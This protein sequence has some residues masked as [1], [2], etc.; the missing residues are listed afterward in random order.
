PAGIGAARGRGG[1][2]ARRPP[3]LPRGLADWPGPAVPH[4]RRPGPRRVAVSCVPACVTIIVVSLCIGG[5]AVSLSIPFIVIFSA[6]GILLGSLLTLYLCA[7]W[8][9]AVPACVIE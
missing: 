5:I 7:L 3:A 9:A 6:V 1:R 4:P 8:Y 2:S